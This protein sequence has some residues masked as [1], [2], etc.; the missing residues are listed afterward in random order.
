[1]FTVEELEACGATLLRRCRLPP[2]QFVRPPS[3][4]EM[5][6]LPAHFICIDGVDATIASA[7]KRRRRLKARWARL[8]QECLMSNTPPLGGVE[9][10]P[11]GTECLRREVGALVRCA[12]PRE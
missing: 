11:K 12:L 10:L 2:V 4:G 8:T 3:L 1:M 9:S 6:P 7:D 5:D